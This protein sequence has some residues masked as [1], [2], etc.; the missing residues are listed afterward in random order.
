M[1]EQ[2]LVEAV[3]LEQRVPHFVE[4]FGLQPIIH[5]RIQNQQPH[6]RHERRLRFTLA[7]RAHSHVGERHQID[8]IAVPR[9]HRVLVLP[10]RAEVL[11]VRHFR[12]RVEQLPLTSASL[13][14]SIMRLRQLLPI[15]QVREL[16]LELHELG[17]GHVPALRLRLHF[18]CPSLSFPAILPPTCATFCASTRATFTTL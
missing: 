18:L 4:H 5:Q 11:V 7:F 10:P 15:Q 3:D 1:Q 6:H 16:L 9:E 8:G 2:E 12:H 14:H 13:P 17:H